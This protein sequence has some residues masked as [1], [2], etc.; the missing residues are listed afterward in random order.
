M[1]NN[2][3]FQ[4]NPRVDIADPRMIG[5]PPRFPRW[6]DQRWSAVL[7]GSDVRD[8]FRDPYAEHSPAERF[9]LRPA[10]FLD[11]ARANSPTRPGSTVSEFAS[12]IYSLYAPKRREA[13]LA[14]GL[15]AEAVI[16]QRRASLVA[17]PAFARI[18]DSK[19]G[20]VHNGLRLND[21]NVTDIP[22]FSI[23]GLQIEGRSLT[24]SPDLLYVHQSTKAALLVEI[25]FTGAYIPTNLW[26]N[27]WAQLWAYSKIP[28][29]SLA[30][31]VKAVAEVWGPEGSI[32]TTHGFDR[33]IFLR[34]T[35]SRDPR[36]VAF[37]LFFSELFR[38]YGGRIS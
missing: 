19:W 2:R 4:R 35:S 27:V 5:F 1:T 21:Q 32:T 37:D 13:A 22:F 30:P 26:P 10:D 9:D 16:F 25:K 17:R 38:H 6:T 20:L 3:S 28:L 12:W 31:S 11:H 23:P 34:C 33:Q 8:P 15:S 7:Q 18:S 24:A 14:A 36:A 29:V